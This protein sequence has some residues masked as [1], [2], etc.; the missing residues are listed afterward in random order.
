LF[1]KQ[2]Q[3]EIFTDYFQKFNAQINREN[4]RRSGTDDA[5]IAKSIAEA[6]ERFS[7][8]SALLPIVFGEESHFM[9]L[10]ENYYTIQKINYLPTA[11][12]S[13]S[14]TTVTAGR[15]IDAAATF[16]TDGVVQGSLVAN[17]VTGEVAYVVAVVIATELIL[18]KNIFNDLADT[19]LISS[20]VNMRNVEKVSQAR[21]TLLNN[22]NLTSPTA[23]YPAYTLSESESI[24]QIVGLYPET[25]TVSGSVITHYVRYPRDPKWTYAD[26]P[27]ISGEPLFDAT[28]PD[29]QDF[30]LPASDEPTL[31]LKILEYAGISIRELPVTDVASKIEDRNTM[32]ERQ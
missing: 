24:S 22:S 5:D 29:Y 4:A 23:S 15:L 26:V 16:G 3:V 12:S 20:T 18:T 31:V 28:Q 1:A 2:A 27:T 17:T 25:I 10:P 32:T 30:E 7:T 19:Y 9:T 21:I 14:V 13:G 6:I 11:L 8:V